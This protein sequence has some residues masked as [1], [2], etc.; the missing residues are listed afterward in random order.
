M[1]GQIGERDTPV[2]QLVEGDA[3][4]VADRAGP[5]ADA[6]HGLAG[7]DGRGHGAGVGAGHEEAGR[8]PDEVDAGVGD[9]ELG[10]RC[11][12]DPVPAAGDAVGQAG[13]GVPFGVHA[14]NVRHA[15]DRNRVSRGVSR[16]RAAS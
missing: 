12:A 4:E 6:D 8:A 16:T 9:H 5:E 13:A 1:T 11:L 2:A 7:R 14:T 10:E 15:S 3:E